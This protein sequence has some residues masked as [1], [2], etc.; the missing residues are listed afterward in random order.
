[1]P[2]QAQS[3]GAVHGNGFLIVAIVAVVVKRENS[4]RENTKKS[5]KIFRGVYALP[6]SRYFIFM[7]RFF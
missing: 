3:K 7:G 5:V 6:L 2:C 1:M 4:Q